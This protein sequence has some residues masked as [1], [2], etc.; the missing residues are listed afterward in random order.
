MMHGSQRAGQIRQT[1]REWKRQLERHIEAAIRRMSNCWGKRSPNPWRES[2]AP[3]SGVPLCWNLRNGPV[4]QL[5]FHYSQVLSHCFKNL[6]TLFLRS[7]DSKQVNDMS[8]L[9]YCVFIWP[10]H[11][12]AVDHCAS[13]ESEASRTDGE[14]F[15]GKAIEGAAGDID[16]IFGGRAKTHASQ[17]EPHAWQLILLE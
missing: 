3:R 6:K 11:P 14:S 2:V 13:L 1:H 16:Q 8:K 9:W 10:S 5:S 17:T 7:I 12:A 4:A 15:V